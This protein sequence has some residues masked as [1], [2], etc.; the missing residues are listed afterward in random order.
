VEIGEENQEK[1]S[2]SSSMQLAT[3]QDFQGFHNSNHKVMLKTPNLKM[4]SPHQKLCE[5]YPGNK[6]IAI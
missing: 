1:S 4:T 3:N 6:I 5:I 2:S